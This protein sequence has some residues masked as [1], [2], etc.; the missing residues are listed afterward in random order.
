MLEQLKLNR[1]PLTDKNALLQQSQVVDK[2][3]VEYYRANDRVSL[4]TLFIQS[5]STLPNHT[6]DK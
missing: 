2:L 1:M 3:V 5:T 4:S 6:P